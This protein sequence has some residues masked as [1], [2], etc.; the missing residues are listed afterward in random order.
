M[1]RKIEVVPYDPAWPEKFRKESKEIK[2]HLGRNCMAV[3]HIGST[4]VEGMWAKPTVDIL[5]TVKDLARVSQ[6]EGYEAFGENGIQGRLFFV[7]GGENHEFHVH[8]FDQNDQV[9]IQRH[10]AV[11]EYLNHHEKKREEYA[12]LKSYLAQAYPEDPEGYWEGK[13]YYVAQLEQEALNNRTQNQQEEEEARSPAISLGMCFGLVLGLT[14]FDNI[15]I[16]LCVGL[17]LALGLSKIKG[18]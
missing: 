16:G 13:S 10:L 14:V 11:V 5:V 2:K 12:Q 4:A 18:K 15:G 8:V 3:Y 6:L 7:K 17:A 9:N 1:G